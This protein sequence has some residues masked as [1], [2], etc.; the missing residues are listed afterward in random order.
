[1]SDRANLRVFLVGFEYA[2][3]DRDLAKIEEI[4]D[5][6]TS[7]PEKLDSLGVHSLLG[8]VRSGYRFKDHIKS[9]PEV[10]QDIKKRLI[11]KIGEARVKDCLVGVYI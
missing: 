1:M 7:T 5:H 10:S 2:V 8:I 3:R 6:Y 4:F 9:F 11:E